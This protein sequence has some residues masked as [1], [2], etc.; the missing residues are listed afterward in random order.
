ME[1]VTVMLQLLFLTKD[2]NNNTGTGIS[3]EVVDKNTNHDNK[4][5]IVE[6]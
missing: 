1:Q 4:T 3:N 6:S 5:P 2:T